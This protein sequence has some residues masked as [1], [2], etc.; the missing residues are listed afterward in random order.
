M[1][2]AAR[3]SFD[4]LEVLVFGEVS[5]GGLSKEDYDHV[6]IYSAPTPGIA[7]KAK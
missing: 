1:E 4:H 2:S 7:M 3:G 5:L 6:H